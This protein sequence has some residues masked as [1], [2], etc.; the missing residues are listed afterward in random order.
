[1]TTKV[2]VINMTLSM[3]GQPPMATPADNNT[4]VKRINAQYPASTKAVLECHPW[5]FPAVW[6]ALERLAET[7]TASQWTYAYNKPS[8]CL[9]MNLV[10]DDGNPDNVTFDAYEDSGGKVYADADAIYLFYISSKWQTKEGS[11]PELFA[12]AVAADIADIVS[13]IATKNLNKNMSASARGRSF[14]KR[15]KSWDASQKPFRELPHGTWSRAR[16]T[17][18]RF[19]TD[20]N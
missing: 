14:L 3:L 16:R 4:W 8:D 10:N 6:V 2:D 18:S 13:P 9:R 12:R 19:N 17:G 5:N 7:S 20:D 15:A 11:W 1:M